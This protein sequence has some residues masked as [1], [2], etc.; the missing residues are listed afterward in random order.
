MEENIPIVYNSLSE[1]KLATIYPAGFLEQLQVM[2]SPGPPGIPGNATSQ[3]FPREFPRIGEFWAGI[4]G[5]FKN[6]VNF[7][8]RF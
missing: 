3:K 7:C 1:E 4:S 6:L 2:S 5:N 8:S